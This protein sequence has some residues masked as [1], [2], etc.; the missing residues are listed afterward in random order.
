MQKDM[1][2]ERHEIVVVR[3]HEHVVVE[4]DD[5]AALL[6]RADAQLLAAHHDVVLHA[7]QRVGE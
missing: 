5:V 7:V 3:Q 2:L 6:L 4:V 1:L